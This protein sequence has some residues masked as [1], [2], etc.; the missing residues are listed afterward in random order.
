MCPVAIAMTLCELGTAHLTPPMECRSVKQ[1]T[2]DTPAGRRHCVEWV[3]L[4][5]VYSY[6]ILMTSNF[7]ALARS[8]QS[9]SSYS[10]YFRESSERV[11]TSLLGRMT[12]HDFSSHVLC[13]SAAERYWCVSRPFCVKFPELY[14]CSQISQRT[15]TG[16]SQRRNCA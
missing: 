16:I 13:I 6:M 15:P 12:H 2:A 1:R 10:G 7:R 4:L 8:A 5:S 9:W 3:F 11:N 14:P